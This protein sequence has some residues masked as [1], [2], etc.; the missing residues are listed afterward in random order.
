MWSAAG[1]L[2]RIALWRDGTDR[3]AMRVYRYSI[4]YLSASFAFAR[5]GGPGLPLRV[6][7]RPRRGALSAAI[8][9]LLLVGC[10]GAEA[11]IQTV[12]GFCSRRW[13]TR[14]PTSRPSRCGRT[15]ERR[16]AYRSAP[17]MTGM[18]ASSLAPQ[19]AQALAEPIRV[20]CRVDE[21]LNVALRLE[22]AE[23]LVA[24]P[25]VS[26]A[27]SA[28]SPSER[29]ELRGRHIRSRH[30]QAARRLRSTCLPFARRRA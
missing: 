18:A 14:R 25:P 10:A 22:D 26:G 17:G 30:R 12:E 7:C 11:Q 21:G 16:C 15:G 23:L 6:I 13:A 27:P 24:G 28:R 2:S 1:L 4:T 8:L 19:G 5:R 3:R 9:A 29:S 20:T